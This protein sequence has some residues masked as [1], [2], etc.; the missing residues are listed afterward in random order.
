MPTGKAGPLPH[1]PAQTTGRLWFLLSLGFVAVARLVG[2]EADP[3]AIMPDPT[4][5]DEGLWADSARGRTLFGGD[6]PGPRGYFA[7]D[8]GNSYLI[9]PLYTWLLTAVYWVFGVGL[10]QTRLLAALMS[11]GTAALAG[12]FVARRSNYHYGTLCVLVMGVCPLL[13]QHGRFALLESSQAFFL[14]ASF[15]L[16]FPLRP[17]MRKAL[18]AGAAMGA[19]MLIKPN[20]LNFGVVPFALAFGVSWFYEARERHAGTHA[21]RLRQGLCITLGGGLVIA[22]PML[23]VWLPHW[24]EFLLTVTYESGGANWFLSDHLLRLGLAGSR[25]SVP[26][27]QHLCALV[28]HAPLITAAL[29]L[30]LARRLAGRTWQSWAGEREL[31]IWAFSALLLA[32]TSYDH[33]S[34]RQVLFVT[35]MA[36]LAVQCWRSRKDA[37]LQRPSDANA[38]SNLLARYLGWLLLLAPV[39][40]VLKPRLANLVGPMLSMS[41]TA[42]GNNYA[43]GL[44]VLG[45]AL[46][47]PLV[48]AMLGSGPQ[49]LLLWL[50]RRG[51]LLLPVLFAYEAA[52]LGAWPPHDY[53][54]REAQQQLQGLVEDDE[55]VLGQHASVMFSSLPVQTVRRV[56]P[57]R[58]YSTP[59]PNPEVAERLRP[60]YVLD[61]ADA[62]LRQFADVTR[63]GFVPIGP[64]VGYLREPSGEF[65]FVLQLWERR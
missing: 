34:R 52:R 50:A 57:G 64:R 54:I 36:I 58:Q 38:P 12:S 21:R 46:A 56:I 30:L 40:I 27:Q 8:L 51:P 48:P 4:I 9:A 3:P 6:G 11:I 14:M 7:D 16:L 31:W 53:T 35:P 61:Y 18:L 32:E 19:A 29:W 28:R 44:L 47:L 45:G 49:A 60:R 63:H 26:G 65:R 10:W 59:R 1:T 5:M 55:I 42:P 25:E 17:S 2:L 37:Q 39:L 20:S 43:A 22:I 33:V 13:D 41:Q 62:Q 15:T 24:D 23:L